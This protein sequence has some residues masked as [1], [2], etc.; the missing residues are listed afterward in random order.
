VQ[1]VET[2]KIQMLGVP[3]GSDEFVA[4]YV[5]SELLPVATRV[6][7]KLAAFED[8][9][10]AMYLLRVS[11][12]IIRANHFMRTTPLAQWAHHAKKFDQLARTATE[13]ILKTVLTAEAYEQACVSP[14]AGG[15]GIRRASDHAPA[16]FNASWFA[17]KARCGE[18][19]AAPIPDMP[20]SATSQSQASEAI[21]TA[22]MGRLMDHADRRD[23]QR[24]SRLNCEHANAWVTALPSEIDG[25]DTI[26]PPPIFITAACRLLGLPVTKSMPCPLCQHT[27]LDSLGDHAICCKKS[28]DTITR[29]NRLRN[30]IYKLADRGLLNPELE[31]QGILGHTEKSK[32][33]PGDVSIPNWSYG[34][35][36]AIDVAVIC[37]VA[38]SHISQAEPCEAYAEK[39]KHGTYDEGFKGT[40]FDFAAV[41]FETSGAVNEEGNDVIRQLIRFA[42]KRE[43]AG[44][45]SY[46][47]RTWARI[48]CSIQYS[49]AQAILNRS[50]EDDEA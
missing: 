46:A 45:S 7:G 12:G 5:G 32:R 10:M 27:F 37:P 4:D 22:I 14:R 21:D 26:L 23:K 50:Y 49:V 2:S 35:A 28:G 30:L 39:E 20:S 18:N 44:N 42:S 17:G 19:W 29:H 43:G 34:R 24:L 15:F 48:S 6:M 33:R 11:Y 40:N 3:L 1:F 9:Q 41:V 47:G 38:E 31:K 13:K 8:S 36:L 16:A 25:K